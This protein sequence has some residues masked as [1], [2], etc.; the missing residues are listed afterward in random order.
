MLN[1]LNIAKIYIIAWCVYY[2]QG[3]FFSEGSLFTRLLVAV[4]L[5]ISL[6]YVFIANTR[7]KL[8]F[9]FWGLNILLG[10]FSV[11]GIYLMIGGYNPT[12]YAVSVPSFYYLKNILISLTPIYTFYVFSKEGLINEKI[13]GFLFVVLFG[14]AVANYY[15]NYQKQLYMALLMGS[16]AEEFTNN[17]GYGF[18]AL[19]PFCAFINKRPILQ[20]IALGSCLVFLFMAMKRGA[21]IIGVLCAIWLMWNNLRD[22]SIKKKIGVLTLSMALCF[23]GYL[24]VENKMQES[25]YFQKRIEDTLEGNSS[26]RDK[27]YVRFVDY[28]MNEATPLQFAVGSGANATLKVGKK[29]AHNDWLEIAVNQGILGL[30][31]YILYWGLF[32]KEILS[33]HYAPREKIA[34]QMLFIIYFMKTIFSM[35]YNDMSIGATMMLGYCLAKEDENEQIIYSN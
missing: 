10:M 17:A 30:L 20:Y 26:G 31:I 6:Y 35:S 22:A 4:L 32:A 5:C 33:K 28:F 25:F 14:C 9:Y 19:I 8:P 1:G 2:S 24:F 15:H 23:I 16:N 3:I 18:L 29:Y 12:E 34:L 11:Y 7:Y 13:L 21:I 27:L